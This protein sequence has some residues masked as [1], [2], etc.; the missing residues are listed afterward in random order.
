MSEIPAG[1]VYDKYHSKNPINRYLVNRFLENLDSIILSINSNSELLDVGCGEGYVLERIAKLENFS[2]VIGMDSSRSII[3][4]ASAAYPHLKFLQGSVY[5]L[6][7]SENEFDTVVACEILE[8]LDNYHK[9]FKELVRVTK[10][11]CI[12]SVPVEPLWRIL[13]LLRGRYIKSLGNTPGHIQHWG[14]NDFKT[15]VGEYFFIEKIYYPLP[16]QILLCSKKSK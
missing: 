11:F 1:N 3:K 2:N 16:W 8:H 10:R 9:A 15:L 7:F 5:D 4:K 12:I 6:P 14:K 13:N